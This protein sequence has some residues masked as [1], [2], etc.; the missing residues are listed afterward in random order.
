MLS[1]LQRSSSAAATHHLPGSVRLGVDAEINRPL[2]LRLPDEL[3]AHVF[4]P[5]TS[6][7]GKTTTLARLAD[8]VVANGYAAIFID[9]KGGDLGATARRLAERYRLPFYLVDPD[10]PESL[11]Y[12]PCSGDASS[13]ANKLVGAFTYGPAAEIYKNIA[14]EAV[15]LAVRGL[16]ASGERESP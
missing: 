15:P 6:G 2:D 4:L 13:V 3:A 1:H 16:I 8:G 12:N 5:G 9:C 10:D 11:G 14:M 7:A